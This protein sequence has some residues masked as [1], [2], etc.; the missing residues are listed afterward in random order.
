MV[1]LHDLQW[2]LFFPPYFKTLNLLRIN[3]L[4]CY[5]SQNPFKW[6]VKL[7]YLDCRSLLGCRAPVLRWEI[8][9]EFQ[10]ICLQCSRLESHHWVGKIPWRRQWLPTP[11]FLPGEF[12]D[13]RAW[14]ATVHGVTNSW[15]QL[16]SLR[17]FYLTSAMLRNL[18]LPERIVWAPT[19]LILFR[20]TPLPWDPS[21]PFCQIPVH[22]SKSTMASNALWLLPSFQHQGKRCF[23]VFSLNVWYV[24]VPVWLHFS[25]W[26]LSVSVSEPVVKDSQSS[27]TF[28]VSFVI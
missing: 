4:S 26:V 13:R 19:S 17:P 10:R 16:T 7:F 24:L 5:L 21:H 14:W 9:K 27:K 11:V 25:R 20:L 6:L 15:T 1:I 12:H 3:R 22:P 28:S 2:S 18:L 8:A 23:F